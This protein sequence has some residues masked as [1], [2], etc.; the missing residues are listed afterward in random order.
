MA[1]ANVGNGNQHITKLLSVPL[2]AMLPTKKADLNVSLA[3]QSAFVFSIG[4]LYLGE[5]EFDEWQR[6]A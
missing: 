4:L 2:L 5:Q 1:V 6:S 3:I